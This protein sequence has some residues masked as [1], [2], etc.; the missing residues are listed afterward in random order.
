MGVNLL[1]QQTMEHHDLLRLSENLTTSVFHLYS[2]ENQTYLL[3]NQLEI[4]NEASTLIKMVI[5]NQKAQTKEG[6]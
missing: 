5:S 2:R 6:I 1:R 3:G 4:I